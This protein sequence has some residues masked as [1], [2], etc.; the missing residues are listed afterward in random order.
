MIVFHDDH[1]TLWVNDK[2]L[3]TIKQWLDPKKRIVE[4]SEKNLN[5]LLNQGFYLQ[6]IGFIAHSDKKHETLVHFDNLYYGDP[7]HE[8][9]VALADLSEKKIQEVNLSLKQC[10]KA[11]QIIWGCLGGCYFILGRFT[12]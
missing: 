1:L 5:N 12:F 9:S 8:E 4:Y 7:V 6:R 11:L 10:F 2:E 3:E